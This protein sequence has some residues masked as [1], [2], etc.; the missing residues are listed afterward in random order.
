VST[1]IGST[2]I[3]PD[4]R[5]LQAHI[6]YISWKRMVVRCRNRFLTPWPLSCKAGSNQR[7]KDLD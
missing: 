2:R 6:H 3:G 1:P 4:I 5:L 7:L